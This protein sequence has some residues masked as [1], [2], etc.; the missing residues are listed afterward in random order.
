[1]NKK[2]SYPIPNFTDRRKSIIFWR[3]LRFQARKILYFPQVRLLEK[4][5]N[6]EK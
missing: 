3:Y 2:F 6:K 1:M 4:T 5:L